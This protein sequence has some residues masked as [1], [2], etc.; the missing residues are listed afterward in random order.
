MC[1]I[2]LRFTDIDV[3]TPHLVKLDD[4]NN[5][6]ARNAF[7]VKLTDQPREIISSNENSTRLLSQHCT[8]SPELADATLKGPFYFK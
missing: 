8:F 3:Y 5:S 6:P 2:R 7:P 4:N 1:F